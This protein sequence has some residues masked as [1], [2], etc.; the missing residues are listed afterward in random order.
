MSHV[1][2]KAEPHVAP[3][4]YHWVSNQGKLTRGVGTRYLRVLD[5]LVEELN[6]NMKKASL[7][8]IVFTNKVK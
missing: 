8:G 3:P 4:C 7:Q 6:N 5:I 2:K 1:K